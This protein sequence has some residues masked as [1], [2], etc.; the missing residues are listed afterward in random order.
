LLIPTGAIEA[1]ITYT[2]GGV[3]TSFHANNDNPIRNVVNPP[4]PNPLNSLNRFLTTLNVTLGG[5]VV[6][7]N[8][9]VGTTAGAAPVAAFTPTQTKFE[10]TCREC[11]PVSF[12]STS[13]DVD[14]D[15]QSL[16]WLLAKSAELDGTPTGS[17][18]DVHLRAAGPV[19]VLVQL[20]RRRAGHGR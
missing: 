16:T 18:P 6:V 17:T 7:I 13:T 8:N 9:M 4:N 15:L 5:G 3:N 2:I 20:P 10:C 19:T 11:T 1:E 12:T 14:N